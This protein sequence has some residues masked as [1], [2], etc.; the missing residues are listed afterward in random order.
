MAKIITNIS[1]L[2]VFFSVFSALQ[3]CKDSDF[4]E[5]FD[6][7]CVSAV[8]VDSPNSGPDGDSDGGTDGDPS[9]DPDVDPGADPDGGP[10][11]G[12]VPVPGELV[13]SFNEE[14]VA[15]AAVASVVPVDVS[16]L[17]GRW[18]FVSAFAYPYDSDSE[19]SRSD[20]II[21]K[22][23]YLTEAGDGSSVDVRHCDSSVVETYLL[24]ADRNFEIPA[25]SAFFDNSELI[26]VTSAGN[27]RMNAQW[28]VDQSNLLHNVEV[29]ASGVMYKT[30]DLDVTLN[31]D[32]LGLLNP[33]L[34]VQCYSYLQYLIE[35]TKTVL[36]FNIPFED[37]I[38]EFVMF[39]DGSVKES[40]SMRRDTLF[41]DDYV[42]VIKFNDNMTGEFECF[43]EWDVTVAADYLSFSGDY[44][45]TVPDASCPIT[46][47][48]AYIVDGMT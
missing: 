43:G 31:D 4:Q 37:E 3:S 10:D 42:Y 9:G 11:P 24:D 6:D 2:L 7:C 12:P 16:T 17:T 21:T 26:S 1:Y 29:T 35:G 48:V 15:L 27:R 44:E 39:L 13:S 28:L 25:S 41:S 22:S 47:P 40:L 8:S 32:Q 20:V 30:G 14:V 18:I 5:V 36:S 38:E 19:T 46:P 34:N 33:D 45:P 23:L